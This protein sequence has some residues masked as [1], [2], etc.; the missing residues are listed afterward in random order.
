MSFER[1]SELLTTAA[2]LLSPALHPYLDPTTAS[3]V[4]VWA[5]R[6]VVSHYINPDPDHSLADSEFATELVDRFFIP[7]LEGNQGPDNPIT[8]SSIND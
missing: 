2:G 8:R 4:V 7:A 5:G 3:E 1:L 6:M